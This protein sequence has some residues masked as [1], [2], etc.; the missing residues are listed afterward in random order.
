MA[1]RVLEVGGFDPGYAVGAERIDTGMNAADGSGAYFVAESDESDG[2][3]RL[4]RPCVAVLHNIE[5]DHVADE[6][7]MEELVRSF[8]AFMGSLPADG[9]ALM[10]ADDARVAEIAAHPRTARAMTYGLVEGELVAR[11]VSSHDFGSRFQV[12][13]RGEFLGEIALRVP[14]AMNVM[15]ALPS[16][17]IGL[18]SGMPFASIAH[19]LAGYPGI[20]RRFEILKRCSRMIVV[21][22][23]AHHPTAVAATIAAARAAFAGPIMVAFQPH[24]YTRTYYL[25]A[26]FARA[27]S[28]ADHILITEIYAASETPIAGVGSSLIGEPLS[29]AGLD[30]RYVD[31]AALP[32]YLLEH[33][34]QGAL[35]LLLG[36]GSITA[37]SARL[38][39]LLD[40]PTQ[41]AV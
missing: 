32:E 14:G 1:A 12:W 30:V 16:I 36:A 23:Y 5:N 28:A 37:A 34:P 6:K 7:E 31:V 18:E 10:C 9:L 33:A 25:A 27:L 4:L 13:L 8:D 11:Q 2:S 3:F 20:R 26:E 21:D 19:A 41:A 22:D 39:D 24:R 40:A 29:A 38:V 15:N 35:V 17:A